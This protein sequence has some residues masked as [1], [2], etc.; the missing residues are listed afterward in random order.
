MQK[1]SSSEENTIEQLKL[2]V[3][4]D[5]I[6]VFTPAGQ[7]KDLPRGATPIDFAYSVHSGLGNH[8]QV[9]KVN[10]SVV[11]L[12]HELQNGDVVE[13]VTNPKV[14]PKLSWL[15]IVKSSHART[16][17]RNYLN[18][19]DKTLVEARH[20]GDE[21]KVQDILHKRML[22]QNPQRLKGKIFL[23][24][25]K[26]EKNN[27][28]DE[29]VFIS[30]ESGLP[31]RF[32]NCCKPLPGQEIIGFVTR[33]NAIT[34]HHNNCKVLAQ[35]ENERII[36]ASWG[37]ELNRKGYSISIFIEAKNRQGLIRDIA[38]AVTK[39]KVNILDFGQAHFDENIVSREM[40]LEIVDQKQL[41]KVIEALKSIQNVIAVRHDEG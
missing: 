4:K 15:S 32:A 16:K 35:S 19:L 13:I 25:I 39:N 33:G 21:K 22:N 24:K 12:N 27:K 23:P 7:V 37:F 29:R 10:G 17:I 26:I 1:P 9:A 14:E 11:S 28:R 20:V 3:F 5:R 36:E 38:E 31:Y 2:D 8:M 6:F 18:A 30:G 34:V 41:N 40:L